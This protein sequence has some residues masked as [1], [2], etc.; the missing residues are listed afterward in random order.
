MLFGFLLGAIVAEAGL[1]IIGYSYPEFYRVDESRGYALRPGMEGWYRKEGG[2]YVRINS[3]GLRDREHSKNK[4]ANTFRIALLG[5]SYP[6]A[7]PVQLEEAFWMVM[8]SKLQGCPAFG[9][10]KVEV[11]NFGVSGYGTALELL[12][13]REHIRDYSPDLVMLAVTTNN[14]ISDNSRALKKTNRVPYFIYRDGQL[15]LDDSF[16]STRTFRLHNSTIGRAG[17]WVYDHSRLV[18]AISQAHHAFKI[19]LASRRSRVQT[20][21]LLSQAS[22]GPNVEVLSEEIGLDNAIYLEPNVPVW[23]EAWRVTEDLITRMASEAKVKGAKFL[24]VTLSNGPQVLPLAEQ[25]QEFMKRLSISDLFYPDNRIRVL[26]ER[27]NIPVI[28]LASEL[29]EY[30]ERNRVY[31][32]GFEN[33]LGSGHW[34]KTGHRVAGELMAQKLCHVAFAK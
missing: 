4:P 19:F 12:T 31:L 27:A 13:L 26:C 34:N 15:V 9:S 14:D 16:K 2:A 22:P 28:N 1:R 5:D 6:E 25:R 18:Q 24:V 23:N 7:F 17:S 30:A 8:E 10:Q 33:N 21:A 32:H 29:Q 20:S 3:D 11:I